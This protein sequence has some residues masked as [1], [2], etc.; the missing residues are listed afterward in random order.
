[1]ARPQSHVSIFLLVVVKGGICVDVPDDFPMMMTMY[2][3]ASTYGGGHR[4]NENMRLFGILLLHAHG[5]I[6][7]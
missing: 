1:M 4:G 6:Q 2:A 7:R 3:A 5:I